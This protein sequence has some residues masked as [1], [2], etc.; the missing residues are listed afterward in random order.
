MGPVKKI[1]G[2]VEF[3]G[4]RKYGLGAREKFE[5]PLC[6]F[7]TLTTVINVYGG[8]KGSVHDGSA[9]DIDI[10]CRHKAHVPI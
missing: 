9:R 2:P 3:L 8:W 5:I 7:S 1:R 4:A 10:M 6:P